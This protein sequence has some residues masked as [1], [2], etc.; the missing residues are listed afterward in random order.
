VLTIERRPNETVVQALT[1]RLR[2]TNPSEVVAV[3]C[4]AVIDAAKLAVHQSEAPE[5]DPPKLVLVP[6]GAEPYRAV[7]RFAVTDDLRGQRPTVVHAAFGSGTVVILS[8]LLATLDP[9]IVAVHVMDTLVHAVESLLSSRTEP[10]SSALASA[11]IGTIISEAQTALTGS[12]RSS[13]GRGRARLV[14]AACLAVEAFSATR[15][16]LAHAVA[17]PLGTALGITHDTINGVLGPALVRF[18]DNDTPG[19]AEV[20]L[21][22]G[23]PAA[24][25]RVAD[26]LDDFRRMAQLPHSLREM[27]ISWDSVVGVLPQ[28]ARSSGMRSLPRPIDTLELE[29]FARSAWE[30]GPDGRTARR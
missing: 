13:L 9:E 18:W 21:A 3:G 5:R 7:A 1:D 30:G 11:A 14:A 25:D 15:L 29:R 22:L 24:A 27:G 19:L 26:V 2:T 20:A 16:G 4:G 8:E 12:H 23:V 17:S 10:V 6:A 28:A